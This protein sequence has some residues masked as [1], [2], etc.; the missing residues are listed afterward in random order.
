MSAAN[1]IL[2]IGGHGKVAQLL[3]PL[4]LRRAWDVTSV[5]RAPAHVAAVEALAAGLPGR[6]RVR[7]CSVADVDSEGAARA[8]LDDLR[9]SCVVWS[10]GAAP[11]SPPP[12]PIPPPPPLSPAAPPNP[13]TPP[14]DGPR[15]DA[16]FAGAGGKGGAEMVRR[17]VVAP[18]G[19]RTHRRRHTA[20]TATP[21]PTSSAPRP[22]PTT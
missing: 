1:H 19:Q 20:S 3:T 11:Y 17:A 9:P 13:P 10:A 15:A 18:R 2:V 22:P 16:T 5:V 8:V 7:V 21:P 6:L 4:L 14:R 12:R